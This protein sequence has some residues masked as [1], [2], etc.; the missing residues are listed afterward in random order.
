MIVDLAQTSVLY[1]LFKPNYH[2]YGEKGQTSAMRTTKYS[3]YASLQD[4]LR[5]LGFK[6]DVSGPNCRFAFAGV[7]VAVMPCD[8]RILGFTNRW[9]SLAMSSAR[10]CTLP[11]GNTIRLIS[12]PAFVATK[13]EAFYDRGKEDFIASH[14]MEDIL[15]V[16]DARPELVDEIKVAD[17]ELRQYIS[18][19]FV[20]LLRHE[21]FIDAIAMH[22]HPDEASQ[23]RTGI[24]L[25]RLRALAALKR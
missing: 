14:D 8:E 10:N 1:T 18:E 4:E 16:V 17:A 2:N 22:L 25:E 12:A 11:D 13:L 15:A 23:A 5:K 7:T 6:H 24:V 21:D 20:R 9:Y 3:D 19:G